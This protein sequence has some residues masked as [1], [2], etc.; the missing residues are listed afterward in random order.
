MESRT[1]KRKRCNEIKDNVVDETHALVMDSAK[2]VSDIQ[3]TNE[4]LAEAVVDLQKGNKRPRVGET[5][6][7]HENL[8]K[9]YAADVRRYLDDIYTSLQGHSKDYNG[10]CD[11]M[12]RE[13]ETFSEAWIKR[14]RDL[15]EQGDEL[16]NQKVQLRVQFHDFKNNVNP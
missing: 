13:F 5:S 4:E 14:L 10:A 8:P 7:V 9:A 1:A 3:N 6:E 16:Q 11:Q 2:L 15:K 12:I